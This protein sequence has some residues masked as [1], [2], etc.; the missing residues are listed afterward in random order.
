MDG[1]VPGSRRLTISERSIFGADIDPTPLEPSG[2]RSRRGAGAAR[3]VGAGAAGAAG[4]TGGAGC[5]VGI[6]CV[7]LAGTE[8]RLSEP[9][10]SEMYEMERVD[11]N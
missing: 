6:G 2:S 8:R 7:Q 9:G 10:Q 1:Q 11:R 5:A 3:A 4:A